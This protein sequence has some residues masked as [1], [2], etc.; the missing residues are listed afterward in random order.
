[1]KKV[2]DVF[3]SLSVSSGVELKF[4]CDNIP[5]VIGDPAR[6]EKVMIEL[7]SNAFKFTKE[8]SVELNV[9][10]IMDMDNEVVIKVVVNDTGIGMT[11]E[12]Q[13]TV[14]SEFETV[15]PTYQGNKGLGLGLYAIKKMIYDMRG[16]IYIDSKVNKGTKFEVIL[17]LKKAILQTDENIF[18]PEKLNVSR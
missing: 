3:L 8:G 5:Y 14:F 1:M 13:S 12:Q 7:L 9:V 18:N 16:E 10:L 6:V 2:V 15:K 4:H 11:K 17:S